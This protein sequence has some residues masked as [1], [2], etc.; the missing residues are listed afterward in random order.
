MDM[1]LKLGQNDLLLLMISASY[2]IRGPDSSY[3]DLKY[4]I[5]KLAEKLHSN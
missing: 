2:V 1:I 5:C 4:V 3:N